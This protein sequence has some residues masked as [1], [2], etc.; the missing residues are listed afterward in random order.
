MNRLRTIFLVVAGIVTLAPVP[1]FAGS[2]RSQG[3]GDVARH[4]ETREAGPGNGGKPVT[5]PY[6]YYGRPPYYDRGD[7]YGRLRRD[8][9]ATAHFWSEKCVRERESGLSPWN[10][11]RDCDNPAYSGGYAPYPG[12]YGYPGYYPPYGGGGDVIIIN[13]Y[14]PPPVFPMPP[15]SPKR[16]PSPLPEFRPP[17][18][19]LQ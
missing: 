14:E 18:R 4:P 6:A 11:T 15:E 1:G 2:E 7:P 9:P 13:R 17:V 19:P 5:P 12:T 16:P 10:H 3:T 8:D